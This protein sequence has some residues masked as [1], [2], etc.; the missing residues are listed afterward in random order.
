MFIISYVI[1]Q[2]YQ[3]TLMHNNEPRVN[4]T[5]INRMPSWYMSLER[6]PLG[7]IGI[8]TFLESNSEVD[9]TFH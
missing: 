5:L 3:N 1:L 6:G 9:S 2:N 8:L 7:P 4:P